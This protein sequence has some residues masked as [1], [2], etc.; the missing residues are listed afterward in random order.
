MR[1][2]TVTAGLAGA[3]MCMLA[4]TESSAYT[5]WSTS[6]P[7]AD[8]GRLLEL[9]SPTPVPLGA[10]VI[11]GLS[12]ITA[13]D[14]QTFFT[15]G[16]GRT[17]SVCGPQEQRPHA[18]KLSDGTRVNENVDV[19]A[20]TTGNRRLIAAVTEEGDQQGN[21]FIHITPDGNWMLS[22]TLSL[23]SGDGTV[24]RMPLYATT[25]TVA[26]PPALARSVAGNPSQ[27]APPEVFD[28]T[29][30]KG[31]AGDFDGDGWWDGILVASGTLPPDAQGR[32]GTPF[33]LYRYFRTD[34][35]VV[36]INS[37][38]IKGLGAPGRGGSPA[39]TKVQHTTHRG[40]LRGAMPSGN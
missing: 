33:V 29:T 38:N 23:D 13:N 19:C 32:P 35:P 6:G 18:G 34:I 10:L 17:P 4:C 39:Q 28:G 36:G 16:G 3:L 9:E 24:M 7:H 27:F 21:A 30:L 1:R 14:L 20:L 12:F 31:R 8:S 22:L 40:A 11:R 15:N 26:V 5:V 37:G 25:G 2:P